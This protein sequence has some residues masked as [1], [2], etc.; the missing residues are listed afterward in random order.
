MS[1]RVRSDACELS[2]GREARA[3]AAARRASFHP[4]FAV[5]GSA[6]R[7]YGSMLGSEDHAE[8]RNGTVRVSALCVTAAEGLRVHNLPFS[9][10][11]APLSELHLRADSV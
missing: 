10:G 1:R 8:E 6:R 2:P 3:P 11:P 9:G 4:Q 7:S 5:T